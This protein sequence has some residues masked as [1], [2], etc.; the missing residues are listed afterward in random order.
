MV[1]EVLRTKTGI[2]GLD[3]ALNGGIPQGNIVLV[4]GGAGTGKSTLCLQFCVNGASLLGEKSLYFS[5]EQNRKELY[6][7][8]NS[9]NWN[10][11]ALEQ[12]NL[13]KIIYFDVTEGDS[14]IEKMSALIEDFK[15]KRIVIDS[16]TTLTDSMLVSGVLDDKGFSMVQIA[17]TVNPIPRTEKI[18]SKSL[19]YHLFKKLKLFG[20]TTLLTTELPEDGKQLSADGVS[21][22][23]SDGVMLLY[24]V[25]V[26][27]ADYRSLDVRK[28]RYTNHDKSTLT[29]D[30]SENGINF[31]ESEL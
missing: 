13:L 6:K 19:L 10:I 28:M 31:K 12:R 14:F 30:L 8:A 23:I 2:Q 11:E 18:V 5:T 26:G 17:E 20:V 27:S 16:L 3:K 22:F 9:F 15:P 1:E 7:Q 25:G 29:Y 21:E 4:S 24:Y